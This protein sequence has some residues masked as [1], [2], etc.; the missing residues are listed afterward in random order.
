MLGCQIFLYRSM[1]AQARELV[2]RMTD[3][4]DWRYGETAYHCQVK[5]GVARY[6]PSEGYTD[7]VYIVEIANDEIEAQLFRGG[8]QAFE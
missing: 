2:S 8:M 7:K 6:G 5:A 4:D 3:Q 1:R